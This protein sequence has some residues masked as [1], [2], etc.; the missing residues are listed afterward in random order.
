MDT[1]GSPER[2]GLEVQ[3]IPAVKLGFSEDI[4]ALRVLDRGFA[5]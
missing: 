4:R 2:S 1:T 3:D 5:A